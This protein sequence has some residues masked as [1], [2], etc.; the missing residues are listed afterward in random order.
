MTMGLKV[1]QIIGDDELRAKAAKRKAASD[2]VLESV[3]ARL[4]GNLKKKE[5]K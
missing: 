5:K 2:E 1:R 3:Y 4:M